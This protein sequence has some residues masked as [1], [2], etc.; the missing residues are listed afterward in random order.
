MQVAVPKAP[1]SLPT[2]ELQ[3]IRSASG[4]LLLSAE[5]AGTSSSSNNQTRENGNTNEQDNTSSPDAGILSTGRV[6]V[7]EKSRSSTTPLL[8]FLYPEPSS[9]D[10]SSSTAEPDSQPSNSI[11][12]TKSVLDAVE[13]ESAPVKPSPKSSLDFFWTISHKTS[14]SKAPP[15]DSN[16]PSSPGGSTPQDG[17]NNNNNAPD[18]LDSNLN[19]NVN[20]GGPTDSQSAPE[21]NTQSASNQSASESKEAT[22]TGPWETR[23]TPQAAFTSSPSRSWMQELR[24]HFRRGGVKVWG[25]DVESALSQDWPELAAVSMIPEC[26]IDWVSTAAAFS[27]MFSVLAVMTWAIMHLV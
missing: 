13:I 21:L 19:S 6:K 3:S 14:R 7:K 4:K 20:P 1:I 2:K 25:A 24:G 10:T 15:S 5:P 8:R 22:K 9:P 17:H 23:Y 26:T 12:A 16:Q 27:A 18:A 11:E